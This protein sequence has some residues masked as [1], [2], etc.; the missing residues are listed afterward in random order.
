MIRGAEAFRNPA[1]VKIQNEVAK[2]YGMTR[3]RMLFRGQSRGKVDARRRAMI[4]CRAELGLST[5][6]IGR[7]FNMHHTTVLHHLEHGDA[8]LDSLAV[9]SG[10]RRK[11]LTL[12]EARAM[13]SRMARQLKDQAVM[14]Q[15]QAEQIAVLAAC[16]GSR[17]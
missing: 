9:R 17:D 7:A 5:V 15:Q 4:R 6:E 8:N 10:R 14:I 13:I 16:N 1:V 2:D 3:E 12:A 11:E